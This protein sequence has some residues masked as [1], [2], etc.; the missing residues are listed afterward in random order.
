MEKLF[1]AGHEIHQ[2]SGAVIGNPVGARFPQFRVARGRTQSQ[3]A[4]S[5]G[6][7]GPN[8]GR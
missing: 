2:K 5:R 8:S 3:H 1:I 4:C 6:F 7:A